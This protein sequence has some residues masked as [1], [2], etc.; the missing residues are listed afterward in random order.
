MCWNSEGSE[1]YI[2]DSLCHRD[3]EMVRP[4]GGMKAFIWHFSGGKCQTGMGF[5][6][7]PQKRII[8]LTEEGANP[9][10]KGEIG[11]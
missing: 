10:S 3:P 6:W 2:P 8:N 5:H 4:S 11:L 9:F 7:A 1:R